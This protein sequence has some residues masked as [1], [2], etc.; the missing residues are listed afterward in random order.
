MVVRRQVQQQVVV[1][2]FAQVVKLNVKLSLVH[3][4]VIRILIVLSMDKY[5]QNVIVVEGVLLVNHHH[6]VLPV[7]MLIITVVV[8]MGLLI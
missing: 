8:L 6:S 5:V 1:R 2:L 7:I 3:Q 4:D